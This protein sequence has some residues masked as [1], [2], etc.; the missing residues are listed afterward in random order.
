MDGYYESLTTLNQEDVPDNKYCIKIQRCTINKG[1]WCI[2][3]LILLI[4][5]AYIVTFLYLIQ[6]DDGSL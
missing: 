3:C 2:C 6:E 5:T 4:Y 1:C